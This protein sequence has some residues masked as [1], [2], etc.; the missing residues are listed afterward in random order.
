[1][2]IVLDTNV[3]VSGLHNPHGAPGRIVDL[4]LGARIHVLYDDRI[5]AEY[6]DVHA[7][8]RLA[9]EPSLAQAVLGCMRLSGNKSWHSL[10]TKTACPI[11]TISHLPKSPL[12][13]MRKCW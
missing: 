13:A 1:M 9:I 5:L 12:Q 8:P 7:R 11:R 2:R 3:L 10:W 4:V 6:R